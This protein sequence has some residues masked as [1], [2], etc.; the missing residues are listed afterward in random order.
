[1]IGQQRWECPRSD[2]AFNV[3][4]TGKQYRCKF[5]DNLLEKASLRAQVREKGSNLRW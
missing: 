4:L 3:Q 1:M 2:F 5:I